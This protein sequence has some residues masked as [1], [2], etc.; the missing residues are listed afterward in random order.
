MLISS[1]N[2]QIIGSS[3]FTK[4]G[5][6]SINPSLFSMVID[7]IPKPLPML[8]KLGNNKPDSSPHPIVLFGT[9]LFVVCLIEC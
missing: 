5:I 8:S 3:S 1:F 4:L 9:K 2:T 6:C 7:L